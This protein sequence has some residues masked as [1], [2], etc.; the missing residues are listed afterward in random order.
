M[1]RL[2][3]AD[4]GGDGDSDADGLHILYLIQNLFD[5]SVFE[6]FQS[7]KVFQIPWMA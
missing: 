6:F 7:L 2:G 5:S 1:W 3:D 4:G